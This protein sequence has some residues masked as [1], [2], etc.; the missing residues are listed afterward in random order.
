MKDSSST[1]EALQPW[2]VRGNDC[3]QL[4][5]DGAAGIRVDATGR[6]P[7]DCC[8]FIHKVAV[9]TRFPG[10]MLPLPLAIQPAIVSPPLTEITCPVM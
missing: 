3:I 2:A 6:L 7:I 1:V 8:Q 10:E 5:E 9:D 4:Q